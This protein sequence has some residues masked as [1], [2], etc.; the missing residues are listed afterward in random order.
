MRV[1]PSTN[2]FTLTSHQR[3]ARAFAAKS[4]E[5]ADELA[6]DETPDLF[7]VFPHLTAD[8]R[9]VLH[10]ATGIAH[11]ADGSVARHTTWKMPAWTLF[12]RIDGDRASGTLTE[13]MTSDYILGLLSRAPIGDPIGVHLQMALDYLRTREERQTVIPGSVDIR[14]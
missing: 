9:R 4:S 10:A 11:A 12:I 14:V 13:L 5:L 6:R 2:A 7:S 3:R 8:D 1:L